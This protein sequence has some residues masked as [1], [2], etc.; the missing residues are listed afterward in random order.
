MLDVMCFVYSLDKLCLINV[1]VKPG[2]GMLI[3]MP[4]ASRKPVCVKNAPVTVAG[5]AFAGRM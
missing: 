2:T 4:M 5:S 3:F 1:T